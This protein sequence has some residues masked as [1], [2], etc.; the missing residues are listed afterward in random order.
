[1]C[2]SSRPRVSIYLMKIIMKIMNVKIEFLSHALTNQMTQCEPHLLEVIV[3]IM[4]VTFIF[5]GF[6]FV[7]RC[8][9][10]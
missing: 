2:F 10:L 9:L 4:A 3:I 8:S 7:H 1:M 6:C 5:A